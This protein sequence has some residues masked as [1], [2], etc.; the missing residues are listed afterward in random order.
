MRS[1]RRTL[2]WGR[3]KPSAS[4][5]CSDAAPDAA[6]SA[7]SAAAPAAPKSGFKV[8]R[9]LS[10]G[11]DK[12]KEAPAAAGAAPEAAE[13]QPTPTRLTAAEFAAAA[14]SPAAGGRSIKRTNSFGRSAK[15]MLTAEQLA[16]AE[17]ERVATEAAQQKQQRLGQKNDIAT[18]QCA[19]RRLVTLFSLSLSSLEPPPRASLS[20]CRR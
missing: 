19:R 3:D 15:S 9:T 17:A 18:S 7:P 10:W 8:T 6:P 5:S 16:A 12:K 4:R 13:L 1:I 2:S 20:P 11:R 14:A